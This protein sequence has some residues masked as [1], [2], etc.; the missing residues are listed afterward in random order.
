MNGFSD[1]VAL[2]TGAGSGIGRA[3]A[4]RF[5]HEGANVVVVDIDEDAGEQR[6]HR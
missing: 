3:T 1:S 4:K 5:A 2:V 6:C